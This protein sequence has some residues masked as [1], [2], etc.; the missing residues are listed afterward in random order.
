MQANGYALNI[1]MKPTPGRE[2]QTGSVVARH[3]AEL[4][5]GAPLQP[6]F[7]SFRPE[8]LAGAMRGGARSAARAA[9]GH[10]VA[11]LVRLR[12]QR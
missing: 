8:A 10:A 7:S 12:V 1:E 3:V 5:D 11:R 6:L 2:L 4:W 9:A